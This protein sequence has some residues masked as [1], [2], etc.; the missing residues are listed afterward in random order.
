MLFTCKAYPSP[1]AHEHFSSSRIFQTETILTQTVQWTAAVDIYLPSSQLPELSSSPKYTE[2]N[3][4]S[5][6][7]I[8]QLSLNLPNASIV[9]CHMRT[10]LLQISLHIHIV[11]ELHCS[12]FCRKGSHLSISGQC[13]SQVFRC[14]VWSGAAMSE[15]CTSSSRKRVNSQ[16]LMQ[17]VSAV[18][19]SHTAEQFH[20]SVLNCDS[21]HFV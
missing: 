10:V 7:Q 15:Y 3:K 12:L 14:A 18:F 17:S 4:S 20:W 16:L 13:S 2:R 11:W 6:Q 5:I 8:H 21:S 9:I 1:N 19:L